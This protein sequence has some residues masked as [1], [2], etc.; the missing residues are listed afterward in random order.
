MN[1]RWVVYVVALAVVTGSLYASG[2]VYNAVV[3]DL[4]SESID[5]IA[6]GEIERARTLLERADRLEPHHGDVEWLLASLD[7]GNQERTLEVLER[8]E[9]ALADRDT[10]SVVDAAT[11][12]ITYARLLYRVRRYYEVLRTIRERDDDDA[13]GLRVQT[14][15]KSQP[16]VSSAETLMEYRRN[17]NT[18]FS[19]W[20][21]FSRQNVP[22]LELY[23]WI[24]NSSVPAGGEDRAYFLRVV[25]HAVPLFD[26][27]MR[28][29]LVDLYYSSG[30]R[31]PMP[32]LY[33]MEARL[34]AGGTVDE[35]AVEM[36]SAIAELD[37]LGGYLVYA[38]I[39]S[40]SDAVKQWTLDRLASQEVIRWDREGDGFA[41]QECALTGGVITR[42]RSDFD[43]D[44]IPEIGVSR[45]GG[46]QLE[47]RAEENTIRFVYE[48]YPFVSRII[49]EPLEGP[50][51]GEVAVLRELRRLDVPSVEQL[52]SPVSLPLEAWVSFNPTGD[53]IMAVE[54]IVE[55]F[56]DDYGEYL[57][58]QDK[59][60]EN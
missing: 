44:G 13:Q 12:E 30:G 28:S 56:M 55:R 41:E 54:D 18:V 24:K 52:L 19:D 50:G 23:T 9:R 27:P 4:V 36:V 33:R 59:P 43:T 39:T 16:G 22:S 20:L 45:L 14:L 37:Q 1:R 2:E 47:Y 57:V 60:E 38:L 42:W 17:S 31:D 29:E 34:E 3:D 5:L 35:S 15:L 48:R 53:E 7:E 32:A 10:L 11:V 8:L 51:P 49:R 6:A 25:A 26:D 21:Y 58:F 40:G 46:V